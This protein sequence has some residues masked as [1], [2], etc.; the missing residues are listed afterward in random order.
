MSNIKGDANKRVFDNIEEI[1]QKFGVDLKLP[2]HI[3]E[4][5]NLLCYEVVDLYDVRFFNHYK[6]N[7]KLYHYVVSRKNWKVSNDSLELEVL[8][9]AE[10]SNSKYAYLHLTQQ[11]DDK[12][13][14]IKVGSIVDT[15]KMFN[16]KYG[17]RFILPLEDDKPKF[18]PER[19]LGVETTGGYIKDVHFS[20]DFDRKI[21]TVQLFNK[22]WYRPQSLNFYISDD[23]DETVS[24]DEYVKLFY[25]TDNT[26]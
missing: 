1:N 17:T 8:E 11:E 23:S 24:L 10:M 19:L 18:V 7:D 12:I 3:P 15:M 5:C 16:E 14:E 6:L 22:H 13:K 21:I 4:G 25:N 20:K 9:D 2:E 26:L